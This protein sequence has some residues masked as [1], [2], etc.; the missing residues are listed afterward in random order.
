[1]DRKLFERFFT[2]GGRTDMRRKQ[3][4]MILALSVL[5]TTAAVP[6]SLY[7]EETPAEEVTEEAPTEE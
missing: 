4:V 1:M 2:I 6:A 5:V 3:A 7:A